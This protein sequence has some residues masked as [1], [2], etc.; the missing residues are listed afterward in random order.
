[1]KKIF[2]FILFGTFIAFGQ[3]GGSSSQED[4]SY[5]PNSAPASPE[6]YAITEY[7]KNGVSESTGKLNLSVPIYNY[8]AGNLSLPISLNY[9]GA[10][11]KVNDMSTWVGMNWN[12]T[13]GG[14]ITRTVNDS[15]DEDGL[16]TRKYINKDTL[17]TYASYL[18]NDYSQG[19]YDIATYPD[20]YD[21]EVDIF[22]FNF[23]GYSGSFY[24]D[25]NFNPIYLENEHELKIT[26]EGTE[27]SNIEKLRNSKIFSITT[28]EGVKYYFGGTATEASLMASGHRAASRVSSTA[29]YLFKIEHPINGTI[30][31]EYRNDVSGRLFNLNKVYNMQTST[32]SSNLYI[33]A[34]TSTLIVNQIDNPKILSKIKSLNNSIEIIFN[35]TVYA[36][37]G[38]LSTLNSIQIKNGS[39]LLKELDF[40]YEARVDNEQV[41]NDFVNATRFFLKKIEINKNIDTSGNK[42]ESYEMEYND[43]FSLPER[44]SNSQDILGYFN[45]VDNLTL[46]PSHPVF[47][48]VSSLSYADRLPNFELASK[49]ALTKITYPT[50]GYSE[51]EYENSKAK[52]KKYVVYE[53]AIQGATIANIPGDNG[54][55]EEATTFSPIYK[56]QEVLINISTNY[57]N[58]G[59][60]TNGLYI[61]QAN[62]SMRVELKIVDITANTPP[63]YFR[64]ALGM[65]PN[66][67]TYNYKFIKDHIYTL[68]LKLINNTNASLIANFNLNVFDGYEMIEGFGVRIKRQK[69]FT[70]Q[71]SNPNNVKRYY[72]GTIDFSSQAIERLPEINMFP[73]ISYFYLPESINDG[74]PTNETNESMFGVGV[75]IHS[76]LAT[77]YFNGSNVEFCEVVST[78]FGGDNFENGGNEKYF[79]YSINESQQRVKVTDDGC[80]HS[81]DLEAQGGLSEGIHCHVIS[82]IN[83][84][85]TQL[86]NM[87]QSFETS[88]KSHYNGKLIGER[89][90]KN[91]NGQLFK[92]SETIIAFDV[93]GATLNNATNLIAKNLFN[94][95]LPLNYCGVDEFG[96]VIGE[97]RQALSSCYFGF[98][99]VYSYNFNLR[100]VTNKEYIQPIPMSLYAPLYDSELSFTILSNPDIDI[101]EA[102]F[103]KIITTQDYLYGTLKGLPTVVTTNT[104]D[105]AVVNKTVNTY[106]N[107]AST[108]PSIPSNQIPIYTSLIAQNRVGS[109]VQVQQYKN[110]ELLS[111]QRTLFNNFTVNSVSKILPEKI[112]ISK[113]EQLLEDKAIFYNYDEH[114]NPVVMGY[115]DASKTRYMFNT[116]GLVV[117]KIENYTGT[118]T[119][120]PLITGNI[121]NTNCALQTQYPNSY[122]TVFKY[123][124][125]TKKLI[126]TTD[127][128]CQNTFYEYDNL[129]R[130]KLIKDHDGNIVKEFDQQFKPQN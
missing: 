87:Y 53:G 60:Q 100:R 105:S 77:K 54:I 68:Q 94:W 49:G 59:E 111:T 113:G 13:A 37:R 79:L 122:V 50:R 89:N 3:N 108:L 20:M 8:T 22:N 91:I 90:F 124:L 75:N 95:D 19:Y 28:P 56:D 64:R 34:F 73:K 30:L 106:V 48:G 14:V 72:Y 128:R 61:Y 93:Y 5:L 45:G 55:L 114:F 65:H 44:L 126:Q 101:I 102:S 58:I 16:I 82:E 9:S 40:S 76:E 24:L 96:N 31:L 63:T 66:T 41:T 81:P 52:Q 97:P 85:I 130:L 71:N 12:L 69:D 35:S 125:I 120:F 10:G 17:T 27:T 119:T 39:D 2:L 18:C 123:N 25:E 38:F 29:F 78:S 127:S 104:S 88:D 98:Y 83:T 112:Q 67:S 107:T 42:H 15:A 21:S 80:F 23:D 129:Q 103:K 118:S 110:T 99:E 26:L 7:G 11:V 115:A 33:P 70:S 84:S 62:K 86:R 36:N 92:I 47:N 121:D 116:E 6:A 4:K 117:A 32:T 1:M 51:F 46:I 74:S 43:P 57:Q 109:P